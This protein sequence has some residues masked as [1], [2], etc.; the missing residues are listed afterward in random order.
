MQGGLPYPKG[1]RQYKIKSKSSDDY[2]A[3]EEV[4][5]RRIQ[6]GNLPDLLILD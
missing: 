2:A 3:L 5:I 4:V 1:Y 6:T